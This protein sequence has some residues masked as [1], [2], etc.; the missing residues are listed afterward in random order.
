MQFTLCD[1][2][3]SRPPSYKIMDIV[4]KK[5]RFGEE[6]ITW[7]GRHRVIKCSP[8][9]FFFRRCLTFEIAQYAHIMSLFCTGKMADAFLLLTKIAME[10]MFYGV[11]NS[12][13][14]TRKDRET[15]MR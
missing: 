5:Y 2:S 9:V 12:G 13:K 10:C 8:F 3:S 4:T 11:D 1:K 15:E 6:I 7:A 14:E